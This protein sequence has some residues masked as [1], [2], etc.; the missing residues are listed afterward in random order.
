MGKIKKKKR[1]KLITGIQVNDYFH[2]STQQAHPIFC[3][4]YLDQEKYTLRTCP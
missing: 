1:A 3:L 2:V 4:K